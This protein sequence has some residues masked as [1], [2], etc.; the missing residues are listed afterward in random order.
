ME[1]NISVNGYALLFTTLPA[2]FD[3]GDDLSQAFYFELKRHFGLDEVAHLG[4][5]IA[6]V[7]HP[8]ALGQLQLLL[9]DV[10][11]P[12]LLSLHAAGLLVQTLDL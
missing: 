1:Y 6:L 2:A 7:V 10:D 4:L 9:L 8:V 3:I 12:V 5:H 11:P